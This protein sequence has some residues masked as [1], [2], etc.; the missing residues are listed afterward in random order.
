MTLEQIA[1]QV[2]NAQ[3]GTENAY[4]LLQSLFDAMAENPDAVPPLQVRD[5]IERAIEYLT[6][7]VKS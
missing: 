2:A 1:A 5:S 3:R 4:H 6:P 7:M